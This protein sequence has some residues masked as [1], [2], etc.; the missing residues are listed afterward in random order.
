ME[1]KDCIFCKIARKEISPLGNGT[2]WEDDKY[3]AWLSPFPNTKGFSV[4]IPKK[5]LPSNAFENT[6]DDLKDLII[7][8]K[9]ASKVLQSGLDDVGRIGMIFEGFGVD[10]L[11]AKLFPMHGTNDMSKWKPL[12]SNVQKYFEK[13]EGYISS[14]DY[15]REDDEKLADLARKIRDN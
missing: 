1:N 3:M 15:K 8:V 13:Y 14:H 12:H 7:A 2:F 9:K 10:H 5:H 4:I 6:D 11:H